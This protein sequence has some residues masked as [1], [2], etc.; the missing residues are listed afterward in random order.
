MLRKQDRAQDDQNQQAQQETDKAQD[1]KDS[2][3]NIEGA[4]ENFGDKMQR[5]TNPNSQSKYT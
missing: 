1:W 3:Q 2:S 4:D 5:N